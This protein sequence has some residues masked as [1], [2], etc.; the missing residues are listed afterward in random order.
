MFALVDVNNMYVSS[1]R[2][3]DPRLDGKPVVVLSSND[4][5]CIARSN[6]AKDLGI[7]MAQPWF[8][9]RH[10]VKT[11]GLV[12]LSANFELYADM[13]ARMMAI[14]ARYTPV[15]IPYSID[16]AFLDFDGVPGDL[17]STGRHL[18]ATVLQE[19]G[20]PTSVGLAGTRTLA[21]LA[22]HTAKSCDRTPANY[23]PE[24]R[25][26]AQVC[27]FGEVS[28]AELQTL[29]SLTDVG[30][31][32]GVG[33]KIAEKLRARGIHTVL[34]LTKADVPS[35]RREF[36]VV[37]EKMVLELRGVPC[38]SLE[39]APAAKQQILVSRS[40]GK[41]VTQVE[42]IVEA[43][44]EFT[45]RAAEKLRQQHS[46]AGAIQVFFT[47]SPY[48]AND[49]QHSPSVTVPLKATS[50]TRHL[51]SA[52]VKAVRQAFRPGFN[53]TKA[54]AMLI[55]LQDHDPAHQ[56]TEL[57]LFEAPA[58]TSAAAN[59]AKDRSAL[60]DAMDKLNQ[61]FGRGAVRVG[62]T[63]SAVANDT[64]TAAWAVKQDRRSPRY[65]TRWDEIPQV[66]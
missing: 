36:S 39:E 8:Q 47:T 37:F 35:L 53:Y 62:S 34:D 9:V 51:V 64:G 56:Q 41:P 55:D 42:A 52:A 3:F 17:T 1:E 54:G 13:S 44:S 26:L 31:V 18:R 15:A 23:P 27:N 10:L 20:L 49:R 12:A 11:H 29:M 38:L 65:T 30:D 46:V 33:R 59:S 61:R 57:D 5:A 6:E 48:R 50:D 43:V 21:K 2:V 24:L 19:L 40:F 25:R 7:K 16:E 28:Q 58:P 22:N 63:T 14:A 32:W 60:M 66:R 4:G 45:S